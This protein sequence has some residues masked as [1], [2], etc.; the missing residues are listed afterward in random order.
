MPEPRFPLELLLMVAEDLRTDDGHLR[1]GDFNSFL[2]VNRV[3]YSMLNPILWRSAAGHVAATTRALWFMMLAN[4]LAGVRKLLALGA[5]VETPLPAFGEI[6]VFHCT[7]YN[8]VAGL[9]APEPLVAAA[10]CDNVPMARLLLEHGASLVHYNWR[11][12]PAYSAMHAAR[13]AEMVRLL[14]DHHADPNQKDDIRDR[15]PRYPVNYYAIRNNIEAM[16]MVL[17]NGAKVNPNDPDRTPLHDAAEYGSIEAVAVLV[18][19]GASVTKT[20]VGRERPLHSAAR[21]GQADIIK[22]L[23]DRW[24][25][26]IRKTDWQGRTPLH[27]A[28]S[29]GKVDAVRALVSLWPGGKK[30]CARGGRTPLMEFQ[31]SGVHLVDEATAAEITVLLDKMVVE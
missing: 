7:S 1:Y 10:E 13:S 21:G 3:L 2:Q 16:Q 23:F 20:I 19:N 6:Q 25:K 12:D 14:L 11:G 22:L 18:E 28:S 17:Q 8:P 26:A 31:Q 24:P 15:S 9:A 4:D 30:A 29:A 27:V 5:N